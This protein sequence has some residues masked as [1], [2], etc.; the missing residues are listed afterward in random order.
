MNTYK[1][2]VLDTRV[3]PAI[4]HEAFINVEK[5]KDAWEGARGFLSDGEK[6]RQLFADKDLK[7]KVEYKAHKELTVAKIVDMKAKNVKLD[8]AQLQA[9]ID[10]PEVPAEEKIEAMKELLGASK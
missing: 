3:S 7:T 6:K 8:K 9:I 1:V 4:V 10:D 2:F 5:Y